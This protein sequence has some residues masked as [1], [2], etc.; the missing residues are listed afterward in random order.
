MGVQIRGS[1]TRMSNQ[2]THATD[3]IFNVTLSLM[4]KNDVESLENSEQPS[5]Q[6]KSVDKPTEKTDISASAQHADNAIMAKMEAILAEVQKNG[7]LLQAL[8]SGQQIKE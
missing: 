8:K 3:A 7:L 2:I 1:T 4:D 6:E 5:D